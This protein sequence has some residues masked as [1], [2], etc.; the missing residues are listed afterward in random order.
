M[1]S[2]SASGWNRRSTA[3]SLLGSRLD[4][5]PATTGHRAGFDFICSTR[6]LIRPRLL[7]ARVSGTVEAVDECGHNLCTLVGRHLQGC[8]YQSGCIQFHFSSLG[9]CGHARWREYTSRRRGQPS[10]SSSR[11]DPAGSSWPPWARSG[12]TSHPLTRLPSL[13]SSPRVSSAPRRRCPSGEPDSGRW[14]VAAES[15]PNAPIRLG[16]VRVA[17]LDLSVPDSETAIPPS[18]EGVDPQ[19]SFSLGEPDIDLFGAKV[20]YPDSGGWA[21]TRTQTHRGPRGPGC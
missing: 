10:L 4:V 20:P 9:P 2:S 7:D 3:T 16:P 14:T 19:A 13:S 21:P 18:A 6:D 15:K 12:Y 11:F 5:L 1:N 17:T 8:V